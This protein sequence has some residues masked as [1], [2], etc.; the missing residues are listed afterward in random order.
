MPNSRRVMRRVRDS[1]VPG[2]N[3][4]PTLF[5]EEFLHPHACCL[6]Q[7]I[8]RNTVLLP[9]SHALCE[10]CERGS[11]R[12]NATGGIC[13]LCGEPFEEDECQAIKDFSQEGEQSQDCSYHSTPC[14]SC[15]DSVLHRDLPRHYKSG[16]RRRKQSGKWNRHS[17]QGDGSGEWSVLAAPGEP[18]LGI[19][20]ALLSSLQSQMNELT[21]QMR[22]LGQELQKA[23]GSLVDAEL[24]LDNELS[25][26]LETLSVASGES[27]DAERRVRIAPQSS[28]GSAEVASGDAGRAGP[29][30]H[31]AAADQKGGEAKADAKVEAKAEAKTGKAVM[32]WALE[33][34]HIL[35]KLEVV[36]NHSLLYLETLRLGAPAHELA[37]CEFVPLGSHDTI[38]AKLSLIARRHPRQRYATYRFVCKSADQLL[39]P[40][41]FDLKLA[42]TA[43]RWHRRVLFFTVIL[44][45]RSPERNL[46]VFVKWGRTLDADRRPP[47]IM[48][49]VLVH[50]DYTKNRA[51]EK[52]GDS[53][54]CFVKL[55]NSSPAASAYPV[56]GVNTRD[57][58]NPRDA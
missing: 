38:D 11:L 45:V 12:R 13:P 46:E 52:V 53:I 41:V 55:E 10:T 42:G 2:V 56:G 3:W 39:K 7:V 26:A 29:G 27:A 44:A 19:D 58:R 21:R 49:V 50:R 47:Q 8:P 17:G 28:T 31:D 51:L 6:C 40:G 48:K 14:L 24:G 15:G 34:R 9:C 37:S 4:R 33:E 35:R 16:C 25:E 5:A 18:K 54:S 23:S 22:E 30:S 43:T 20:D 1:E 32:P 57:A 36:A